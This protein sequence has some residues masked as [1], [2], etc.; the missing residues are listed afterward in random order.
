MPGWLFQI[1]TAKPYLGMLVCLG[2]AMPVFGQGNPA[3]ASDSLEAIR[4]QLQEL[5][6]SL[7]DMRGQFAASKGESA[8]LRR[9]IQSLRDELRRVRND[10]A[11]S[12]S[13]GSAGPSGKPDDRRADLAE[14]QRLIAAK[15]D[16]H[17][18]TKVASGSRYRVRLSGMVL[19]NAFHTRGA[20][21]NIDLP[22]TARPIGPGESGG[23]SAATVRQSLLSLEVF[24]PQWGGAKT[25]GELKFDFFGGFPATTEGV[26]SGLVRLRTATLRLEWE[27]TS[28]VAGQ[29]TPFFSPLSPTSLASTAYPALSAAGNLWT[30]T[31]QIY[32]ERRV[33]WSDSTRL[34]FQ[35]GLLDALTGELPV[36]EY[37]RT[38]N[39]GERSGQPAEAV[40]V[41]WQRTVGGRTA[42][43][44]AGAYYARQNWG[45]DRTVDAW[46]VTSDWDLPLGRW[47]SLSGELYRGRAIGGLGGGASGSVIFGGSPALP[48]TAVLALNSAGG[49]SQLKFQPLEKLQFNA[50]FGK[51][52]SFGPGL[53]GLPN[54]L[55]LVHRNASGFVNLIY[56]PRSNLQLSVEY[57]RLWTSRFGA[58]FVTA[59][60]FGLGAGIL[61]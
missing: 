17:E 2:L 31:P 25:S 22:L 47:F 53:T 15:V 1:A 57:R 4:A 19:L 39:A 28:I 51:D 18:Q 14:E 59:D 37:V 60:H 29:D 33:N 48:A 16:E 11:A 36:T 12:W 40:R 43:V 32:F 46:T 58:P 21:D 24:G 20:V 41:A 61:F 3:A 52:G 8:A 23:S 27:N 10:D 6:S 55:G 45:F 13:G 50:A 5:R 9:E 42:I 34:S 44:G 26:T 35:V 7:D 49:W 38:P 54:A 30:W 56:Q